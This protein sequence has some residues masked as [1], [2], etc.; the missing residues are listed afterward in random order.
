MMAYKPRHINIYI[1]LC[2]K[3]NGIKIEI[4]IKMH[5]PLYMRKLRKNYPGDNRHLKHVLKLF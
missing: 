1:C 2:E 5:Y 3:Q 4:F